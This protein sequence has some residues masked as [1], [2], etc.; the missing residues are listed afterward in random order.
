MP[1]NTISWSCNNCTLSFIRNYQVVFL[2]DCI[3]LHPHKQHMRTPSSVSS[4]ASS[5]I[6]TFYFGYSDRYVVISSVVLIGIFLVANEYKHLFMCLFDISIPSLSKCLFLSFA[7]F[8]SANFLFF[9][10][11]YSWV[12]NLIYAGHTVC[13]SFLS[14][15]NLSFHPLNK[16]VCR[17][18]ILNVHDIY[19]VN[20]LIV[21]C[22]FLLSSRS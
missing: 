19:F 1:K 7:P 3:I 10:F 6:A 11:F 13:K 16:V 22:G 15:C 5:V 17:A 18:N 12:W 14:A 9:F 8:S 4:P 2:K 20:F 21:G